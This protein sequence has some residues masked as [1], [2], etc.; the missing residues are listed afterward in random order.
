M[1]LL[2][3]SIPY[4][5]TVPGVLSLRPRAL[6]TVLAIHSGEMETV[7]ARMQ[8]ELGSLA[9]K[10]KAHSKSF[11]LP[12]NLDF[13]K[14]SHAATKTLIACYWK[15]KRSRTPYRIT[16]TREQLA[17]AAQLSLPHLRK[18]LI[19][20]QKKRL[21]DIKQ[22][23]RKGIQISLLD[24]EYES[25][26]ALYH[27]AEFNRMRLNT[28]PAFEWYRLLLHDPTIPVDTRHEWDARE[29]DYV[30]QDC[31]FCHRSKKF[32]V[33]LILAENKASYEKDAW[34]CHGCKRGGD[35]KRLW[36]LLHYKIDRQDWRDALKRK[37]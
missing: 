19:E 28:V 20:L 17:E 3:C 32:R 35:S 29:L 31:P 11:M 30:V 5:L 8:R 27:I 34:Y 12:T 13:S 15:S 18:A 6:R 10:V 7:P 36:G 4:F 1:N 22:L 37:G 16:L 23:W 21:V 25:G 9:S 24:P 33:T 14:L 26:T 2:D